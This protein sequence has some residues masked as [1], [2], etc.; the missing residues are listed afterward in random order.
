MPSP[1]PGM[2][3]YLEHPDIWPD[4]HHSLITEVQA[5]LNA[6]L[7]PTRYVARVELR[8]F[9]FEPDDPASEVYVI[10][11]ARVVER[12]RSPSADLAR[13]RAGGAAVAARP[14]ATPI[15]VTALS[16]AVARER[17]LEIRD[18]ADRRVVTVIEVVSPSNKTAGSAGRK[19]FLAKRAE[20]GDSEASWLEIDL[21]RG[22]TPTFA[23]PQ[24]P[25][26]A[27]RAY[28]DRTTVD[29][30]RRLAWPIL[31]RE[32]LPVLGVPL[33]P[34]DDDVP[35]DLQAVLQSAYARAA[36]DLD[37]DYSRAPVPPL[38]DDDAG[39]ADELLSAHRLR[40]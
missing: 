20:V 13:P 28:A 23:Y 19:A 33:R 21:L 31:L 18:T 38:G 32:P 36:Y 16:P 6:A 11:D 8:T 5:Q 39:W 4:V 22:G 29:E 7:R 9:M 25:R 26:S 1:F 40:S 3:P 37:T 12:D 15:D 24:V 34:G 27:Y 30:R 35:L 2:D 17:Y 14:V 10:P